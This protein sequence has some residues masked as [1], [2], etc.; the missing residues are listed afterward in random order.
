[1]P[2]RVAALA[3]A[4]EA[5]LKLPEV[6]PTLETVMGAVVLFVTR[7]AAAVSILLRVPANVP[8]QEEALRTQVSI[9]FAK[10]N[11]SD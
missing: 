6:D 2:R 5:V 8:V 7:F 1:M 4:F 11:R 9:P 10:S 3:E